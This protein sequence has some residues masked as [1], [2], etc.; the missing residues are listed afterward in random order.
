VSQLL[1]IPENLSQS[2]KSLKNVKELKAI[3]KASTCETVVISAS[4]KARTP[5]FN[6]VLKLLLNL[7]GLADFKSILLCT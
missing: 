3:H 1:L 5:Y 6:K 7:E 2:D 4:L